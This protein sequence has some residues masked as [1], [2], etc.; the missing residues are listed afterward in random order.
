MSTWLTV[1]EE[2]ALLERVAAGDRAA[3]EELIVRNLP[4]ISFVVK[5]AIL[6]RGYEW[7]DLHSI[8]AIGLISAADRY[9]LSYRVRFGT[10]AVRCI[11]TAI[12]NSSRVQRKREKKYGRPLAL[13]RPVRKDGDATLLD[14]VPSRGAG[15]E[16]EVADADEL[17]TLRAALDALPDDLRQFAALRFEGEG[18]TQVAAGKVMG[19]SQMTANRRNQVILARCRAALGARGEM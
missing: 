15:P 18:M 6:P 3:R 13:D 12:W 8:G 4:L 14:F 9:D 16:D 19:W 1:E 11:R 17:R 2:R 5:R 10:F 7:A